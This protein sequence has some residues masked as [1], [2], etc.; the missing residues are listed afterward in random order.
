M[1]KINYV[2]ILSIMLCVT[3]QSI[4]GQTIRNE[5]PQQIDGVWY[6][7]YISNKEDIYYATSLKH[8]STSGG[9]IIDKKNYTINFEYPANNL[10][11]DAQTEYK[12]TTHNQ[13]KTA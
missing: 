1:K 12:K 4:L 13:R 2:F 10:S 11:F 9:N 6:S 8:E 7:A 5:K 3:L